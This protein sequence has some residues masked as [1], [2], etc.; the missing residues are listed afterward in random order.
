MSCN[1][2]SANGL[3]Y[4][5]EYHAWLAERFRAGYTMQDG[6]GQI[7]T[8]VNG[9]VY[10]LDPSLP[11]EIQALR[12]QTSGFGAEAIL[13][14]NGTLVGSL[15]HAGAY[16]LPLSRGRHTIMVED[17]GGSSLPVTFEVR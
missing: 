2:H 13:Y 5:P 14:S 6:R 16:T 7:R 10:F 8:P 12:V 11:P 9:S 1:W 17:L 15:N 3:Y 4:P